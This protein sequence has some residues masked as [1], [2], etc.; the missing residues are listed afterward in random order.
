[1]LAKFM[2]VGFFPPI[3]ISFVHQTPAFEPFGRKK[4]LN[5]KRLKKIFSNF[6]AAVT[7]RVTDYF[8]RNMRMVYLNLIF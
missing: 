1:M 7:M 5:L 6:L 4:K 8:T 2:S 3:F